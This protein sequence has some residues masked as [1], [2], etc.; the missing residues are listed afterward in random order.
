MFGLV[1]ILVITN[2]IQDRIKV[3]ISFTRSQV[4]KEVKGNPW[5][6]LIRWPGV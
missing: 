2:P 1:F 6:A 4:N 5:K 3:T